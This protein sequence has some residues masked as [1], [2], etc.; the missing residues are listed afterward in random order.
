[1]NVLQ[2]GSSLLSWQMIVF[3]ENVILVKNSPGLHVLAVGEQS[4]S[5]AQK[6]CRGCHPWVAV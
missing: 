5:A 2:L 1:M 6:E 3:F 4:K